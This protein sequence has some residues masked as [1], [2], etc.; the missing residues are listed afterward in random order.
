MALTIE[1]L[2][3][4]NSG[5]QKT[6]ADQ[7]Q[8]VF[9]VLEYSQCLSKIGEDFLKVAAQVGSAEFEALGF[10]MVGIGERMCA[11]L[12]KTACDSYDSRLDYADMAT[13][14]YDATR[15]MD[16]LYEYT[17]NPT[18]GEYVKVAATITDALVDEVGL[19]YANQV[20]MEKNADTGL[21]NE[22]RM[23]DYAAEARKAA[24]VKATRDYLNDLANSSSA[25]TASTPKESL[26]KRINR[27]AGNAYKSSKSAIVGAYNTSA[28]AVWR[29]RGALGKSGTIAA[30]AALLGG[31][32]YGIHRLTREKS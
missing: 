15:Y 12:S 8:G 16:A 22:T 4:L 6:A 2:I 26:M 25:S 9:E 13:D 31:A 14:L 29:K 11:G 18:L 17:G 10:D 3:N 7:V 28:D 23:A 1:Q 20:Y 32:G 5:Y 27:A 21:P 19:D 24:E 30:A